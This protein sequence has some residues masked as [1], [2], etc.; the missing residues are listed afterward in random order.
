MDNV[1]AIAVIG[2]GIMGRRLLAH[3]RLHPR[4]RPVAMWDPNAAAVEKARAEAPGVPVAVSAEAA[5]AAAEVVYLACPPA[6]RKA[7]AL[8]AAESGRAVFLEKP[9]GVDVE[10]SRDLVARLAALGRPAAVNFTQAAGR[11][12]AEIRRAA[13][14]GEMGKLA[15]VDIVVTYPA[16]PRAW[17]VDA[18]W[19]RFRAEGG[20]TREVISHFVFFSERL[21]G[22]T[23]LVWSRP[24][25][26]AD[27]ALCETHIQARLEAADGTPVS[28]LGTVGGAQPDRQEM[29]IKGTKRSYRVAEFYQLWSSSGEPFVEVLE[30]PADPRRDSLMRQLDE[31]DKCLRRAPHLLATPEEAFRVQERI[32]GMLA[33]R[34]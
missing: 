22:P 30:R 13:D 32:E 12:L 34:G 15:G 20:Y 11:A 24:S 9:L 14:A 16:W 4:F 10:E 17:Q 7:Y 25:Y 1:H 2:L 29:T 26:P 6:P 18:D 3:L 5:I 23:R 8:A 33:G 19:L 28:I 31:L 27:P 21:V